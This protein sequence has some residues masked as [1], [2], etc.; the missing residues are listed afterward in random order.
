[1]L[2]AGIYLGRGA[3]HPADTRDNIIRDNMISG[4]GMKTHCI[5]A[6]PGVALKANTIQGNTVLRQRGCAVT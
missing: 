2:E 1:M 5:A 6:A 4:H 3:E